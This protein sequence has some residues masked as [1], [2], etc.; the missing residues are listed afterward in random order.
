MQTQGHS[1][2]RDSEKRL[3]QVGLIPWTLVVAYLLA[4]SA[5]WYPQLSWASTIVA[6]RTSLYPTMGAEVLGVAL[7]LSRLASP[8]AEI[9]FFSLIKIIHKEGQVASKFSVLGDP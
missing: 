9:I 4:R 6:S 1:G 3:R 5:T 7:V 8:A 2:I